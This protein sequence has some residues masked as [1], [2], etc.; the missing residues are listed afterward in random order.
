MQHGKV[1]KAELRLNLGQTGYTQVNRTSVESALARELYLLFKV[2]LSCQK[3]WYYRLDSKRVCSNTAE[4]ERCERY[5][6]S[7]PAVKS[8]LNLGLTFIHTLV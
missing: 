7:T 1:L 4:L 3:D 2:N 8:R 5:I 6:A